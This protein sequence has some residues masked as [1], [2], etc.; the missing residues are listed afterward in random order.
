EASGVLNLHLTMSGTLRSPVF[1]GAIGVVKGTYNGTTVPDFR[2]TF[3]YA[4]QEL[5]T[6]GEALRATGV[7]IAKIDG[8]IPIDLAL[9][10]V[11]GARL[12]PRPMAVDIVADSLPLDLVPQFTDLV[13]NVHGHAAGKISMRGTLRRPELVGGLVLGDGS[14][15][16]SAT[17]ATVEDINATVRM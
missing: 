14:M 16:I 7:P 5:V 3:D 10:G 11:S 12:S 4:N 1:R 17:G 6:Q 15:T 8:R 9:T 13:S 2:A